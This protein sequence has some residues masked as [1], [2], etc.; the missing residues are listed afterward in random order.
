MTTSKK[1]RRGLPSKQ[2]SVTPLPIVSIYPDGAIDTARILDSLIRADL[3]NNPP[4]AQ[5]PSAPLP[6]IRGESGENE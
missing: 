2:R 4:G 3:T 1:N 6:A 5:E